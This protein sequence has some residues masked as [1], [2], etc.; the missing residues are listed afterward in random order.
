MVGNPGGGLIGQSLSGGRYRVDAELGEGGM[1]VVYRAWDNNLGTEVVIKVPHASMLQDAEFAARF[2][3]EIRSLV[4]LSHP[5]IVKISDVGE[6][7][8]LPFAVM[9]FLPGGSLED[10]QRTKAGGETQ[11]LR[12]D[13][14]EAWLP[15]VAEA[16]DFVHQQGYI[17]RDVK[18]A[19]ILFDAHGHAYLSDF[20]IAKLAAASHASAGSKTVT[21]AG[22]VIGTPEYM[23]PELIMGHRID[24]GVDQYA[25]AV[26]TFEILAGRRPFEDATSTAVLVQHSTK[27]PPDLASLSS[28]VSAGLAAVIRKTLSKTPGDRFA[29]CRKFAEA[30]L[31]E[32]HASS[33]TNDIRVNCPVCHKML[34]LSDKMRGRGVICPGCQTG[35]RVS[36]DLRQLVVSKSAG[37]AA[38]GGTGTKVVRA[39]TPASSQAMLPSETP[40]A[41]TKQT[42]LRTVNNPPASPSTPT[43]AIG[44]ARPSTKTV[45]P[46]TSPKKPS[47]ITESPVSAPEQSP[48]TG[49]NKRVA[50]GSVSAAVVLLIVI[51]IFLMTGRGSAK[52]TVKGS[53]E[54]A[55]VKVDENHAIVAGQVKSGDGQAKNDDAKVI[56][57][58]RDGEASKKRGPSWMGLQYWPA[59]LSK[60]VA[61]ALGASDG[62]LGVIYVTQDGPAEKAGVRCGDVFVKFDNQAIRNTE[63]FVA[64]GIN[65]IEAGTKHSVVVLRDKRE[66][67]L[68]MTLSERPAD[69][70]TATIAPS[71]FPIPPRY[72]GEV[73]NIKK[74]FRGRGLLS[75][76]VQD[77][78]LIARDASDNVGFWSITGPSAFPLPEFRTECVGAA[79]SEDGK[80]AILATGERTILLWSI[81]DGKE[82]GELAVEEG[83]KIKGVAMSRD[84]N[85]AATLDKDAMLKIWDVGNRKLSHNWNLSTIGAQSN[86]LIWGSTVDLGSVSPSSRFVS[87]NNATTIVLWNI[88]TGR[89]AWTWHGSVRVTCHAMSPDWRLVAI[90]H[91]DGPIEVVDVHLNKSIGNLRGHKS[92]VEA[93]T[94][95]GSQLLASA[96]DAD[97]SIRIWDIS[98]LKQ[99]WQYDLEETA[100][101]TFHFGPRA[102]AFSK[103]RPTL[104]TGVYTL[105]EFEIPSVDPSNWVIDDP[106]TEA[107]DFA[108]LSSTSLN[109]KSS[110]A[111]LQITDSTVV[112]SGNGAVTH[113]ITFSDRSEANFDGERLDDNTHI[114]FRAKRGEP[115]M[116]SNFGLAVA[117]KDGR[118]VAKAV[119]KGGD[120]YKA[121]IRDGMQIIAIGEG[122]SDTMLTMPTA[123][124]EEAAIMRLRMLHGTPGSVAFVELRKDATRDDQSNEI[125]K[126]TRTRSNP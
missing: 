12:P 45:K 47:G 58:I 84:G 43:S 110:A 92:D 109:H 126:I 59:N 97:R 93:L 117:V 94:W 7:D 17:H 64:I 76:S 54:S 5:H 25:L 40:R 103:K 50:V 95:H 115:P 106:T 63:D 35:L 91:E 49:R 41:Q 67:V 116:K 113:S 80:T 71:Y 32:V 15:S 27:E 118:V 112:T 69:V 82:A 31:A 120:A 18:P 104:W 24:G 73:A 21:G 19:N 16:L 125:I 81:A 34:K 29:N 23:A 36:D 98:K 65:G 100:N 42:A 6:T 38:A 28:N 121:G 46:P 96:C 20:G 79:V 8:G 14:L 51:T 52:I 33:A 3:L 111:V 53:G 88:L 55:Q 74:T 119:K 102:V 37:D 87:T 114:V 75:I 11:P 89:V 56:V 77:E 99:V 13:S 1:G 124:D 86:L 108:K 39:P 57:N 85:R 48:P 72:F 122:S 68:E 62:G 2:S 90:A 10:R 83:V 70:Q 9:Q 101:N 44:S 4:A 26:T 66:V 105:R 30:V 107:V 22:L 123:D 78:T 61:D 60:V